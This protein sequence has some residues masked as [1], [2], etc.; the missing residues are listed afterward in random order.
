MTYE[1]DANNEFIDQLDSY[2]DHEQVMSELAEMGDNSLWAR[3]DVM[4][5]IVPIKE[6]L[7]GRPKNHPEKDGADKTITDLAVAGRMSLGYASD[8]RSTSSFFPRKSFERSKLL[9]HGI[10]WSWSNLARRRFPDDTEIALDELITAKR[11]KNLKTYR[12]F[13]LYLEQKY[14]ENGQPFEPKVFDVWNF[15]GLDGRFGKPHPG[16][17]PAGIVLN[18]VYYW[19]QKGALVVDPMAGGGVTIDV[20][21]FMERRCLAFDI[22]PRRDDIRRLDVGEGYPKSAHGCDLIFVDP[23]YWKKKSNEYDPAAISNL[24][25]DHYLAFFEKFARDSFTTLGGGGYLAFLMSNYVD[26][27][28]PSGSIWVDDYIRMF[29]DAGFGRVREIQCPLTTQQYAAHDVESAKVNKSLLS[30]TRSLW[31]L[32]KP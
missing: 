14:P 6:T 30:I 8:V 24:P 3:G 13:K 28:K 10:D 19:T 11:D 1:L 15:A 5:H 17:I 20:C 23:P 18:A 16:N 9:E 27:E 7:K 2:D 26:F 32:R 12:D 29:E 31:I 21:K 25:R 22:Q 4:L